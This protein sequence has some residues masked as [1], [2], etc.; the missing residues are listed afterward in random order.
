MTQLTLVG[1]CGSLRA[2]ST[3]RLLLQEAAHR[4]GPCTYSELDI[5]FPLFD[6]DMQADP[7]IPA[8]V[9]QAARAIADA[10]AVI[11]ASPEYNKGISGALKNALDWISRTPGAPWRDKPVA[12]MSAAA[13]A[14]GGPRA[15]AMTRLCLTAFR[16]LLLPGPEVMVG[17]TST[18]WDAGGRLTDAT[19]I[20]LLDELMADLRRAAEAHAA[21]PKMDTDT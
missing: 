9:S 13:G 8:E 11:V 18:K 17:N 3:N 7:G 16:P 15:Q 1:L 14:A 2:A 19:G 20:R 10:D 4:F 21:R 5:R 12:L 6:A